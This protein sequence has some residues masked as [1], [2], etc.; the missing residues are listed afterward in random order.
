MNNMDDSVNRGY[1]IIEVGRPIETAEEVLLRN[2]A[3]IGLQRE[4]EDEILDRYQR[5]KR[6]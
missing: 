3:L 2:G 4:R 1:I 6:T 5:R